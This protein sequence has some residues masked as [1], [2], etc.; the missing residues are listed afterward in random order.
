MHAA[1][2]DECTGEPWAFG[3]VCNVI[4]AVARLPRPVPHRGALSVWRICPEVVADVRAKKE[5]DPAWFDGLLAQYMRIFTNG[6]AALDA[7]DMPALG[8]LLTFPRSLPSLAA[9]TARFGTPYVFLSQ[10]RDAFGGPMHFDMICTGTLSM[11]HRGHKR[12]SLWA[13][14]ELRDA[15]GARVP[16]HQRYEAVAR[17][18][19][20]V[21]YPPAWFHATR[22]DE[23]GGASLTTAVDLAEVPAFGTLGGRSLRS[24]FGYGTCAAGPRGWHAQSAAWDRALLGAEECAAKNPEHA[25]ASRARE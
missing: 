13:P 14:W 17:P 1:Q 10:P 8:R 23:D 4:T 22:V 2:L 3:P 15:D 6:E 19:D 24:P 25:H 9:V 21:Y 18:G 11:Q 12:W 20:V 5:A 16:A 7:G